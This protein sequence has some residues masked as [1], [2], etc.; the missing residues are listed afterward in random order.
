[1]TSPIAVALMG[2]VGHGKTHVLNKVCGT[3]HASHGGAA[4]VTRVVELGYSRNKRIALVGTPGL[5]ATEDVA[6]HVANQKLALEYTPLSGVYLIIKCGRDGDMIDDQINDIIDMVGEESIRIIITHADVEER[7]EGY[8]EK[9]VKRSVSRLAD[10]PEEFVKVIS[11]T[12][13]ADEIEEFIESTLLQQPK[14]IELKIDQVARL[15]SHSKQTRRISKAIRD[16]YGKID[17]ATQYCDDI[18][19]SGKRKGYENDVLILDIQHATTSMVRVEKESIFRDSMLLSI[20]EQMVCYAQTGASL[21][22]KLKAFVEATNSFL[23][24]NVTD[25]TDPRNHYRACNFCGA[26]FVK[27]EGC[28]GSTTCGALP[29]SSTMDTARQSTYYGHACKWFKRGRDWCLATER[30]DRAYRRSQPSSKVSQAQRQ[31]GATFENG[32]GRTVNWSSML[33]IEPEL[34]AVLGK[35]EAVCPGTFEDLCSQRFTTEVRVQEELSRNI[36]D[37]SLK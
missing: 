22:V 1:M 34:V 27:V 37:E 21:S 4:S 26:V 35:V 17:A 31:S 5:G 24:W 15:G 33:P 8:D 19:S 10:I 6:R 2:K 29:S 9:V 11:I 32:C 14:A 23:S 13:T 3:H 30:P 7:K 20:D 16:V 12:S 18:T 28:D 25:L 36:L